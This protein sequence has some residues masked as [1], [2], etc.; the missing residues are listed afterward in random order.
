MS[1]DM[2]SG[3]LVARKTS[4]WR[5]TLRCW[6]VAGL[7]YAARA[8]AIREGYVWH[9]MSPVKT[10]AKQ[11]SLDSKIAGVTVSNVCTVAAYCA[12]AND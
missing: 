5:E 12:D 4:Q 9:P 1:D 7:E 11:L 6:A 3:S 8:T 10:D 2:E